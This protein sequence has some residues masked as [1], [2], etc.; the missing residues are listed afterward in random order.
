MY[1]SPSKS[2]S[3]GS[4][5]FESDIHNKNKKLEE[6]IVLEITELRYFFKINSIKFKI[7]IKLNK[8]NYGTLIIWFN[9]QLF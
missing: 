4:I 1:F 6:N 9:K 3:F 2:T 5:S 8:N 7:F